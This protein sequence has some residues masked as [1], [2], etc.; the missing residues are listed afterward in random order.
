MAG[1][2]RT[3]ATRLAPTVNPGIDPEPKGKTEWKL[4]GFRGIRRHIWWSGMSSRR[5]KRVGD[6]ALHLRSSITGVAA[7]EQRESVAA[8]GHVV[9]PLQRGYI[10]PPQPADELKRRRLAA[11]L[12]FKGKP[13]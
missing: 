13:S 9:A 7:L 11:V 12:Q 10:P 1:E 2:F 8:V 3:K 6:N 5:F 4:A